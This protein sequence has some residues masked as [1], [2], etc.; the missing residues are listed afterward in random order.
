MANHTDQMRLFM[1]LTEAEYKGP[2]ESPHVTYSAEEKK[3]E[4][5]KVIATLQSYDSGRYTK[6]GRNLNRI[7][8]LSEK[9]DQLKEQVKADTKGAIADL[10]HAEDACRTRVVETVGFTFEMTKDPK[11]TTT[12]QYAKVLEALEEHLTPELIMVL[13]GLKS[14]FSSSTQK[15]AALKAKDKRNESIEGD[16]MLSEGILDSLKALASKFLAKV[17]NWAKSYD[18]KLAK[19]K[20]MANQSQPTEE[21]AMPMLEGDETATKW[22]DQLIYDAT[23]LGKALGGQISQDQI[24]DWQRKVDEG[25]SLIAKYL[26]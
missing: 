18:S 21:S 22:L 9:V 7:K 10:F 23:S 8:W 3:G 12:V 5:T 26:K 6:L 16:D 13:E 1:K 14:Q 11:A 4:I 2:I 15:S 20:A 19:L 17:T 25:R 24:D